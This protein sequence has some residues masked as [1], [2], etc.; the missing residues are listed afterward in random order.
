MKNK[1]LE[2]IPDADVLIVCA[3]AAEAGP[4][5]K[6]YDLRHL[7]SEY[8]FKLYGL[9]LKKQ[10]KAIEQ[11]SAINVLVSGVGKVNMAAALMWSQ[12]FC[13]PKAFINHGIAGHGSIDIGES[14][15]VNK[16]F[17][18][19]KKKSYYPS[20]YFSWKEKTAQLKTVDMPSDEYLDD[21]AY[22]MEGSA[23]CD[24]VSRFVDTGNAHILKV[25]SD[26]AEQNYQHVSRQSLQ[27]NIE[28]SLPLLNSL[29]EHFLI[30]EVEK[31]EGVKDIIKL[32]HEKWHITVAQDQ[33]LK[34]VLLS[35]QVIEKNTGLIAPDWESFDHLKDFLQISK[36]WVINT[37]PNLTM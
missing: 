14:V 12:K 18:E 11:T 1:S 15:L 17:D 27:K 13:T 4:I 29:V 31:K 36:K 21:Y 32:M 26:N 10:H 19:A 24:I 9:S 37:K 2:I 34:D 22:D 23:F 35:I 6:H 30:K 28:A 8:G 20:I 25:I 5:V 16:I 33:Q 7:A 3:L